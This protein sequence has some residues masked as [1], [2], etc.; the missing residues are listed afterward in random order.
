ML[1]GEATQSTTMFRSGE[2]EKTATTFTLFFCA[3]ING[4]AKLTQEQVIDI[5]KRSHSGESNIALGEEYGLHPD[6][7]GR[8]RNKKLWKDLLDNIEGTLND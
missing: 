1:P 8:I 5:Y 6:S 3:K 7:I 2:M 4:A